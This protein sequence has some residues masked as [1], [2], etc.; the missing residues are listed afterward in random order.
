MEE[1]SEIHK[2]IG[3][4]LTRDDKHVTCPVQPAMLTEA[5]GNLALAPGQIQ[6]VIQKMSCTQMCRA[7]RVAI[8]DGKKYAL[9]DYLKIGSKLEEQNEHS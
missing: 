2:I 8:K 1:N 3:G 5:P 9:C 7:F 4:V 6:V